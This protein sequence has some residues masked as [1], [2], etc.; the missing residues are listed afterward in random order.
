LLPG[1]DLQTSARR[2]QDPRVRG[3]DVAGRVEAVGKNVIRFQPGNELFGTCRGSFAEVRV[4]S[5]GPARPKAGE[6]QL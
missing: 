6:P 3:Y 2:A 1:W 4:R 5:S